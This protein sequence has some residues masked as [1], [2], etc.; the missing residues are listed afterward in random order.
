MPY[1]M[2]LWAR[3]WHPLRTPKHLGGH[4]GVRGLANENDAEIWLSGLMRS[5]L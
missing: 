3:V 2:N 1:K 5:S 4:V